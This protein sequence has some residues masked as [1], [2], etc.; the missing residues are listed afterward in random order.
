MPFREVALPDE[1]PGR[2]F[3]HSM[4]GSRE[5]LSD[6]VSSSSR[7][8]IS[9]VVC[10]APLEEIAVKSPDYGIARERGA[11]PFTFHDIHI[12]DYGL[13]SDPEAFCV[14]ILAIAAKLM[15]GAGVLVHCGAG[16]GRTGMAAAC[17]LRTLGLSQRDALR[18]VQ[19]AGSGPETPQQSAFVHSFSQG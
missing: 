6:F 2:L 9:D 13:P 12:A 5:P 16:I 17:I 10:L 14:G 4:P 19:E 15:G 11:F 8:G 1:V 3:L 7:T 18:R